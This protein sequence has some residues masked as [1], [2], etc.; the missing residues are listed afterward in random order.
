MTGAEGASI[1]PL[2]KPSKLFALSCVEFKDELEEKMESCYA[3][4]L[5]RIREVS[6]SEMH[7]ALMVLVG[8]NMQDDVSLGLF[9]GILTNPARA[10]LYYRG[11]TFITRDGMSFVLTKANWIV[12]EMFAKLVDTAREQLLWFFREAI[13]SGIAYM[14]SITLNMFRWC[15]VGDLSARN[16]WLVDTMLNLLL[17]NRPWMDKNINVIPHAVYSFLRLIPDHLGETYEALR[18]K[19]TH[20]CISMLRERFAEC[21]VIGRDLIRILVSVGGLPQF[22]ALWRDLLLNPTSFSP[23]FTG[24]EQLLSI[25]TSRRYF[26]SRLSFELERRLFFLLINVKTVNQHYYLEWIEK[27]CLFRP[28]CNS[29]K[30][31]VVRYVCSCVHP[32]NT[33]L[34]SDVIPRWSFIVWILSTCSDPVESQQC[35]LALFFDWLFFDIEQDSIMNIEPGLL[36]AYQCCRSQPSITASLLEFL[37]LITAEFYPSGK[38]AMKSCVRQA[39]KLMLDKGVV[40]TLAPLIDSICYNAN[41]KASL[42]DL[43]P[44]GTYIRQGE[45]SMPVE[46]SPMEISIAL[47][48]M[49]MVSDDAEFSDEETEEQVVIVEE[50]K[51]KGPTVKRPPSTG[52]EEKTAPI[53]IS[54]SALIDPLLKTAEIDIEKPLVLLDQTLRPMIEDMKAM[55]EDRAAQCDQMQSLLLAI[56]RLEDFEEEQASC[57]ADCLCTLFK[58]LFNRKVFISKE[59]RA[60]ADFLNSHPLFVIFRNLCLTPEEDPSRQPLLLL[61]AE[62]YEKQGRIGYLLLYFLRTSSCGDKNMSPYRDLAKVLSRELQE[63]LVSDLDMCVNDDLYLF[64]FL[65][66][67]LVGLFTTATT[68]LAQLI[69][70]I[71][72]NTDSLLFHDFLVQLTQGD[73]QLF[74]RDTFSGVLQASLAW[75]TI[76]QLFFWQLVS[77]ER[78][79]MDWIQSLIPKLEYPKHTEAMTFIS[80]LL[81]HLERDP[82]TV[83]VRLILSRDPTNDKDLWAVSMLQFLIDEYDERIAELVAAQLAKLVASNGSSSVVTSKGG[84]KVAPKVPTLEQ[85]LS[86][87]DRYRCFT[88]RC[89]IFFSKDAVAN[90]LNQVKRNCSEEV[91]TQFAELFGILEVLDS[92]RGDNRSLRRARRPVVSNPNPTVDDSSSED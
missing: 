21:S 43:M 84:R 15:L 23:Q 50:Q 1:K 80:I 53:E 76:E 89:H 64:F 32:N 61:L 44:E 11:L 87:L 78:V 55:G 71:V 31:D 59:V 60:D 4:L 8:Q 67:D 42:L 68:H 49:D 10:P 90:A 47:S 57:L 52:V 33:V 58:P 39:F 77:A 16:L 56:F 27:Q 85:V 46:P 41:L 88:R 38:E 24:I 75:E 82:S 54:R 9:Y 26:I 37:S 20:F 65:L 79:P 72:A 28:E 19:E 69:H 81:R 13:R 45:V 63:M 30:Q 83:L 25:R 51:D 29:L 35:K 74:R 22:A 48:S 18:Q 2:R 62:M 5:S 7:D 6:E 36:A 91:K 3:L 14:E 66:P 12:I 40:V 92:V 86:H 34:A 73:F 70:L 17:E